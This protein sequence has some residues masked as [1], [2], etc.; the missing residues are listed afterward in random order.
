[1]NQCHKV[2]TEWLRFIYCRGDSTVKS[3]LSCQLLTFQIDSVELLGRYVF[4]LSLLGG[5]FQNNSILTSSKVNLF[6]YFY[7][8]QDK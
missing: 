3:L 5:Y 2:C 4:S 8:I 1:M 6:L 7:L